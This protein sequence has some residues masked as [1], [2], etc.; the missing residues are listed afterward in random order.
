MEA[1]PWFWIWIIAAALLFI[2]EMLT[3]S[4]FLLPFAVGAVAAA[5]CNA[6][7]LD[8]VWQIVVFIA[9]SVVALV[10]LRPLARRWTRKA[11]AT[12]VGAERLVGLQGKVIEGQS[13]TGLFRVVVDGEPWNAATT[14]DTTLKPGTFIEV[15]AVNSNMLLVKAL[16]QD[17]S[18]ETTGAES[19]ALS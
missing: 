12:K 11:G 3:L 5:I 13:Q 10:A 18:S 14:D 17:P 4:F 8:L 19:T 7:G 9:V 16:P 15:L 2:G 1:L 6:V